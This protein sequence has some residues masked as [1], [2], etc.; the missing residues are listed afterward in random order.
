MRWSGSGKMD[1]WRR[2]YRCRTGLWPVI[3]HVCNPRH[4]WLLECRGKRLTMDDRELDD[5]QDACPTLRTAGDRWVALLG[6]GLMIALALP[7]LTGCRTTPPVGEADR[8][9]IQDRAT[10]QL[11]RVMMAKPDEASATAFPLAPLILVETTPTVSPVLPTE[12]L[13][14]TNR[15]LMRGDELMQVAFVWAVG[16]EGGNGNGMEDE[17]FMQGVRLTLNADGQPVIWEVLRDSSGARVF[18]VTQSLEAEAMRQHDEPLPGRRFW[19]E[20]GR[21]GSDV[22]AN[23]LDEAAV[24]MGPILYI[25][26]EHGD[27]IGII[28]RCMPAQAR[29]VLGTRVYRVR[30]VGSREWADLPA[31]VRRALAPWRPDGTPED[32]SP[33]FRPKP[34]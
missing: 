11:D 33:L 26:A 5:R 20:S 13:M 23:V 22:I 25:E 29:E 32:L 34:D 27:V 28:C 21:G 19:I 30:G 6:H 2:H 16:S 12:L 9:E 15:V 18:Y 24:P 14:W 3:K 7:G 8:L 31:A 4:L 10:R 1:T 17:S